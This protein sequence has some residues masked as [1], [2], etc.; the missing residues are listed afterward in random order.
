MGV[1]EYR[2]GKIWDWRNMGSGEGERENFGW[3]Y[4]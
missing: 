4:Y 1:E 2:G 3:I